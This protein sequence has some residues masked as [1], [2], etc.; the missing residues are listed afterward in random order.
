MSSKDIVFQYLGEQIAL[1]ANPKQFLL[2]SYTHVND[3]AHTYFRISCHECKSWHEKAILD[4]SRRYSLDELTQFVVLFV[5]DH[6]HGHVGGLV[7]E[8]KPTVEAHPKG[9][10]KFRDV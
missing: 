3:I 4:L 10:R 7:G 9:Y 6:K 5:Q 8:V 2:Q 1:Y